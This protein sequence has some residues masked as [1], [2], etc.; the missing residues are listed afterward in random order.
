VEEAVEERAPAEE[1]VEERAPAEEAV[2]APAFEQVNLSPRRSIAFIGSPAD[3][4]L[5]IR[6]S[7]PVVWAM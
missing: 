3:A 4:F 1:A 7:R 6:L 5:S 2:E